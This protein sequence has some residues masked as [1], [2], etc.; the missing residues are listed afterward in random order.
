V[1][2]TL[3]ISRARK[4]PSLAVAPALP[5]N[6]LVIP[7]EVR[8]GTK[9]LCLGK[10]IASKKY[11]ISKKKGISGQKVNIHKYFE[12]CGENSFIHNTI[13]PILGTQGGGPPMNIRIIL[14]T[15]CMAYVGFLWMG[16]G[17]QSLNTATFSGAVIGA[18]CGLLLAIMFEHR[19]R[20]KKRSAHVR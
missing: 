17:A 6:R 10:P 12:F 18:V 8:L 7:T 4:I 20:R 9:A 1:P 13:M 19:A 16:R 5:V 11:S 3:L 15:L 14:W 2:T